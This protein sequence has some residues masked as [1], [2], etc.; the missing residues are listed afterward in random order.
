MEHLQGEGLQ[1]TLAGIG[2]TANT[3]RDRENRE[4]EHLQGYGLQRTLAGIGGTLTEIRTTENT[5]RDRDYREHL[6]G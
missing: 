1:R 6:R 5:C 2:T 3:Y 4:R